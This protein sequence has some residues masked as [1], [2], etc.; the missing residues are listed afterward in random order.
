MDKVFLRGARV[1]LREKTV[2]D[3]WN[4]YLWRTDP[5]LSQLDAALPLTMGYDEF[6]SM[7]KEQLRYPLAWAKPLSVDTLDGAYIGNCMYYDVDVVHKTAEVGVLIGNRRYWND[8]YGFEVVVTLVEHI[9]ATTGLNRLYLH[10]LKWNKR[11][12][13][14]FEKCGFQAVRAGASQPAAVCVHGAAAGGVGGAAGGEAGG[15][16]RFGEGGFGVGG[17]RDDGTIWCLYLRG[18]RDLPNR[19]SIHRSSRCHLSSNF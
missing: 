7:Y 4:E 12:L 11:A 14:C 17:V 15:A 9:F 16:G 3:A 10:T 19:S 5:E 18:I 2:K 1:V 6:L 13:R 8:G